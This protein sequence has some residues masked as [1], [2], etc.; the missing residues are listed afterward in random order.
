MNF[1]QVMR[2]MQQT[3]GDLILPLEQ[4]VDVT[5]NLPV[6]HLPDEVRHQYHLRNPE[7]LLIVQ[8]ERKADLYVLKK[9]F[10]V[11]E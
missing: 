3:G 1:F 2:F 8:Y 7:L 6:S 11:P 10:G 4:L 9:D 5:G